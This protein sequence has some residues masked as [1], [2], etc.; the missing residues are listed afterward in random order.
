MRPT[1]RDR[2]GTKPADGRRSRTLLRS[3]ASPHAQALVDYAFARRLDGSASD[4]PTALEV[5]RVVHAMF[6]AL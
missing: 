3:N 5:T 6:V 1:D 4:L 2:S